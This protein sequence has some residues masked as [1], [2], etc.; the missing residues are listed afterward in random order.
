MISWS[1]RRKLKIITITFFIFLFLTVSVYFIFLKEKPNCFDGFK[2]GLEEGV[3]CGGNC[4][5][6]C[7]FR[8]TG[9]NTLWARAFLI[10]DGV[11]N[12]MALIENPNF[13]YQVK[14]TYTI[15]AYDAR[16]AKIFEHKNNILLLPA[17]KRAIFLPTIISRNEK[18]SK[19]F[20]NFDEI[21]SLVK[22]SPAENKITI[23]SKNITENFSQT[24]LKVNLK[25]NTLQPLRN[26]EVIGVLSDKN[27]NVIQVGKTFLNYLN[28]EEE[29]EIFITWPQSF[30]EKVTIIDVYLKE[31]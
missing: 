10:K 21:E 27:N 1:K 15:L 17:E 3:D 12:L 26:I 6:I 18:I 24:K 25:N 31:I 4:S 30:S 5:E 29:K 7:I 23:L 16:G 20:I 2:N 28:K 8:A 9:I 13:N 14:T 22:A 11:Y 19:V